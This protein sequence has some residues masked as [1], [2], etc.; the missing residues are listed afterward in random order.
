MTLKSLLKET[1]VSL[2][3]SATLITPVFANT[4]IIYIDNVKIDTSDEP[5]IKN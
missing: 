3:L 2:L 5:Y 4:T 1:S